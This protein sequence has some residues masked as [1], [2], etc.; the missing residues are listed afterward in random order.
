MQ[1]G[2]RGRRGELHATVLP[3]DWI[4]FH[5]NGPRHREH[6]VDKNSGEKLRARTILGGIMPP[7][8]RLIFEPALNA[9][10]ASCT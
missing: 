2:R 3:T 6:S 8:K 10:P 5:V 7:I 1:R 9:P 4:L